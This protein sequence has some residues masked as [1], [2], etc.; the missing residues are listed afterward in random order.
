[1]WQYPKSGLPLWSLWP[2]CL[3]DVVL[4]ALK[5]LGPFGLEKPG[6]W[7]WSNV[8]GGGEKEQSHAWNL[9]Q[10]PRRAPRRLQDLPKLLSQGSREA[11]SLELI[12]FS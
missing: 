9:L 1:M 12:L 11:Q 2:V 8:P 5:A 7:G 4:D 10:R 6:S 3:L